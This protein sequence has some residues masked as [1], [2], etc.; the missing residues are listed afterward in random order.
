MR[1]RW[2]LS[3]PVLLSALGKDADE[4]YANVLSGRQDS[5]IKNRKG[6]NVARYSTECADVLEGLVKDSIEALREPAASVLAKVP[7]DRVGLV[8]GNCDYF[9]QNAVD[10]HRKYIGTG[11]FS[12]YDISFQSPHKIAEIISGSLGIKGPS[13]SVATACASSATSLARAC[14]LIDAGVS[15]VVLAG[16]IDTSTDIIVD[17]FSSLS[18]VSPEPANPFSRN[19]KGITLGDGAAYFFLS[20]ERLF[21]FPV[22]LTGFGETSDGYNMTSPDP[23]ARQVMGCMRKALS[24]AGLD[25]KEIDYIN[26]HGTGTRANDSMEGLA[27]SSLFPKGTS[28]SS[29]KALTGHTLAA[30]GALEL[31]ISALAI[32]SGKGLPPHLYDGETEE[33][34]ASLRFVPVGDSS[35][36]RS[37]LSASFAF[38]GA[39]AAMILERYDA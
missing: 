6:F 20:R 25:A 13:F 23:E 36:A 16:G 11:S 7:A 33:E 22:V 24:M 15:D 19:R 12:G 34:A 35:K 37:V 4:V 30:A 2:Y 10:Y 38:G 21:P 5:F 1:K 14:D 32:A 9:S 31:G 3:K 27:V 17:G 18:A 29:T 28:V 39:N 26:L 8:I